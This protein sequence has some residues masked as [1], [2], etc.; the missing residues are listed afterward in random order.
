MSWIQKLYE[1]YNYCQPWV[2]KYGEVDERPLLPICHISARAHIEIVIDQQGNFLKAYLVEK[3]HS[4]TIVP[5]TEQSASKVGSKPV[6]HP[7]CEKLQY[8]AGDFTKYGGEVTSGFKDDPEEPYRN[9]IE[10]LTKWCGSEFAHPK[11][12]AVLKYVEKK[13]V[14]K[15][16]VNYQLLLVGSDGKFLAKKETKREKDKKDIFSTVNS[17]QDKAFVRWV[18][19]SDEVGETEVWKDK[20]I[21]VSWMRYYFST[22]EKEPLCLVTGEEAVLTNNHPKY[23][24]TSSDG[25]KLISSNDT[26]GFT[27]LGRFLTDQQACTISL[28]ASQKAHSA[29]LWLIDRQGQVFRNDK[30]APELTIVAWAITDKKIPQPTDSSLD[31]V[32]DSEAE[33]PYTAENFATKFRNKILGYK[34]ELGETKGVQVMAMDA[35]S[36]GRLAITYYRELKGS[37]YLERLERWHQGCS[38]LHT[39]GYDKK[40]NKHFPFVGSPSPLDIAEA[41]YGKKADDKLKNTTIARLIP[42][43]VDGQ[44]IPRDLVES[45]VKRASNRIGIKDLK[46]KKEKEWNKTLS[47]AC[48]LFKKFKEKKENYDMSLDENRTSRDYL[49]G[50]LLAI[51]ERLEEAALYKAKEK[52]ATNAARY[53]QQFSQHPFRTWNQL[54]SALTP[55]IVRLGGAVYYKKIIADVTCLFDPDEFKKDTPLTAEYLL[56]YYCQRQKLWERTKASPLFDG[57]EDSDESSEE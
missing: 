31:L 52:R 48:A 42:C 9:F 8:V 36:K 13:S 7:L 56:G 34:A 50:R 1:T 32:N 22:K 55:Y 54:H 53:M 49:Y 45:A 16:L 41:A 33:P 47:I 25:A 43:V 26:K 30:K 39:Y 51:A 14:V 46:D 19:E 24:R 18:V 35:A 3:Q 28:E 10:I 6:G 23:I 21:W 15:D 40:T 29:L 11:A 17:Q 5:C 4:I 12:Q 2:G 38:W 57:I 27:Y 20:T 37:D 44:A